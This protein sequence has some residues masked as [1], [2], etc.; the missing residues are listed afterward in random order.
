M[1]LFDV[2]CFQF[3]SLAS[4]LSWEKFHLYL[5]IIDFCINQVEYSKIK[6]SIKVYFIVIVK[7][8]TYFLL[9]LFTYLSISEREIL[10]YFIQIYSSQLGFPG[11]SVVKN[12]PAN[13]GAS[14]DMGST[15]GSGKSPGRGNGNPLQYSCLNMARMIYSLQDCKE[16]D[17]VERLSTHTHASLQFQSISLCI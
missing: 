15:L 5:K 12:L 3:Y 10:N 17:M 6:L 16:L 11:G 7:Y 9:L 2:Y 4:C 14:R 1:Q 13:T 8:L